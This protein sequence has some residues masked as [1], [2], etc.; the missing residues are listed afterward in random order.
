M[1]GSDAC[2]QSFT[3]PLGDVYISLYWFTSACNGWARISLLSLYI[4]WSHI[5][6]IPTLELLCYSLESLCVSVFEG[7]N[8]KGLQTKARGSVLRLFRSQACQAL[9]I[10]WFLHTLYISKDTNT[11][12]NFWEVW[13]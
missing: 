7:T 5:A 3:V 1:I 6:S 2:S 11:V 9:V 4:C 12:R 10:F 13:V 8:K